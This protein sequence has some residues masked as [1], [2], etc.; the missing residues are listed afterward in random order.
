MVTKPTTTPPKPDA[1]D[2]EATTTTIKV[3]GADYNL[4]GLSIEDGNKIYGALPP[5]YQKLADSYAKLAKEF[6]SPVKVDLPKGMSFATAWKDYL[7]APRDAAG[8]IVDRSKPWMVQLE[9]Q[10]EP[11]LKEMPGYKTY[12][13][14]KSV[15]DFG[16]T[17]LQGVIDFAKLP[18][19]GGDFAVSGV[20]ELWRASTPAISDA[21]A[22]AFGAAYAGALFHEGAVRTAMP[23]IDSPFNKDRSLFWSYPVESSLA[24]LEHASMKWPLVKDIWPLIAGFAKWAM[25]AIGHIGQEG[26]TRGLSEV[27]DSVK[28]EIA[29]KQQG[30]D[31]SWRGLT[32]GRLR[33]SE[34]GRASDKMRAAEKVAGVDTKARTDFAEHG[35]TYINQKGNLSTVTPTGGGNVSTNESLIPGSNGKPPKKQGYVERMLDKASNLL[36]PTGKNLFDPK[37]DE[38]DAPGLIGLGFGAAATVPFTEGYR[39]ARVRGMERVVKQLGGRATVLEE[40]AANAAKGVTDGTL[41]S[42]ANKAV[43]GRLPFYNEG[44]EA[45]QLAENAKKWADEALELRAREAAMKEVLESRKAGLTKGFFGTNTGNDLKGIIHAPGNLV[46]QIGGM[47]G[48]GANGAQHATGNMVEAAGRQ[49]VREVDDVK[50]MARNVVTFPERVVAGVKGLKTNFDDFMDGKS[51]Q[52]MEAF[53]G[54]TKAAGEAAPA[55][56]PVVAAADAATDVAKVAE[57]AARGNRIG[58]F[59]MRGSKIPK[60]GGVLVVIGGAM[61][62]SALLAGTAN[63]ATATEAEKEALKAADAQNSFGSLVGFASF[64]AGAGVSDGGQKKRVEIEEAMMKRIPDAQVNKLIALAPAGEYRT[65]QGFFADIGWNKNDRANDATLDRIARL[66]DMQAR[67]VKTVQMNTHESNVS[68]TGLDSAFAPVIEDPTQKMNTYNERVVPIEEAIRLN[69]RWYLAREGTTEDARKAYADP[70]ARPKVT[71]EQIDRFVDNLPQGN[72]KTGNSALDSLLFIREE[73]KHRSGMGGAPL[74]PA[75]QRAVVER[76]AASYLKAG[77]SLEQATALMNKEAETGLQLAAAEAT[78]KA[79][80]AKSKSPE[81]KAQA[82]ARPVAQGMTSKVAF[83]AVH[84]VHKG[85]ADLLEQAGDALDNFKDSLPKLTKNLPF[86]NLFS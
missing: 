13:D 41:A 38:K 20:T 43:G 27:I 29:E 85:G 79:Q 28:N 37:L 50:L 36:G 75:Q 44:K 48:L 80:A 82:A 54:A 25:E 67:G 17:M 53:K 49:I 58:N 18:F 42:K 9:Q 35:G 5:D 51:A 56:K 84:S 12:K 73:V 26:K 3:G 74:A 83:S 22:K 59:F 55:A 11:I 24:G 10:F 72:M 66:K 6:E 70:K 64:G 33:E 76:Y 23:M 40:R 52:R 47:F 86:P 21:Q 45:G 60:V 69:A 68:A 32:E 77:G 57:A 19:R 15:A 61:G 1:A 62:G 30:R 7:N 31:T 2:A 16:G 39:A 63:A 71:P 4:K 34:M 65:Q 46:R 78:M 81:A 8:K 14:T